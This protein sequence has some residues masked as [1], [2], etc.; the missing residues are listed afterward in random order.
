M[1]DEST[2]RKY[3]KKNIEFLNT[4]DLPCPEPGEEVEDYQDRIEAQFS[5]AKLP[6]FLHG[7]LFD[8]LD[9]QTFSEYIVDRFDL[10]PCSEQLCYNLYFNLK[11]EER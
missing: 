2:W 3:E 6:E 10:H 1:C 5:D 7:D 8:Y 4:L 11:T 9:K